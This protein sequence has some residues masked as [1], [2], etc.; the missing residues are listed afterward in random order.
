MRE[1]CDKE[2]DSVGGGVMLPWNYT[3]TVSITKNFNTVP[4]S[5]YALNQ[6]NH[7]FQGLGNISWNAPIN[8]TSNHG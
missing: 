3:K 7:G 2:L 8:I 4:V 5:V 1:L 6:D